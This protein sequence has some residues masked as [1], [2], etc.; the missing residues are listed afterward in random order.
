MSDG[1]RV[2]VV[3]DER[4]LADSIAEGLRLHAMAVDVAYDGEA[5]LERASI[6]D[7]DVLVLDRDL[8]IVSGDE[9]CATLVHR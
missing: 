4:Q 5:G 2:L 8:P 3:E 1:V 9:V 7:Y 6:N